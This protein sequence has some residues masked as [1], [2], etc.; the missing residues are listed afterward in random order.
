M[1][2]AVYA[3]GK[4]LV[5]RGWS[6]SVL[7]RTELGIPTHYETQGIRVERRDS[8]PLYHSSVLPLFIKELKKSV[9]L[10]DILQFEN[11]NVWSL[12]ALQ[13][14]APVTILRHFDLHPVE[15]ASL[16]LTSGAFDVI[17]CPTH[18]A[19]KELEDRGVT[20]RIEVI[21]TGVDT[22]LFTPEGGSTLRETLACP[23]K[24][25]ILLPAR[26]DPHKEIDSL[27]EAIAL[28]S[29]DVVLYI[30]GGG[31]S[32]QGLSQT[33]L[34]KYVKKAASLNISHRVIFGNGHLWE[35]MPSI[36]RGADVVVLTSSY[37]SL[38][39]ALMEAMACGKPV[40]GSNIP[41]IGEY[42]KSGTNGILV[43]PQ[44]PESIAEGIDL[45]LSDP[46]KAN[47][48]ASE[49]TR[50]I[51]RLYSLERTVKTY[52]SLVDTLR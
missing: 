50:T 22:D 10:C 44:N 41:S 29:H 5:A 52:V 43:E 2:I 1:D 32:W 19:K 46:H 51:N 25:I 42:I 28:L 16:V 4:E 6:V 33:L 36:Y 38:G 15:V 27:L 21:S 12:A 39:L 35:E 30:T 45:L 49:G 47:Q 17:I 26:I 8:F 14:R 18:H 40:V 11:P 24:K 7:S 13:V 34:K 23:E 3:L 20:E 37:E 48:I 31:E 9:E